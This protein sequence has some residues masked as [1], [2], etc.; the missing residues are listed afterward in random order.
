MIEID[1]AILTKRGN[2]RIGDLNNILPPGIEVNPAL[3]E[4]T[5]LIEMG[6]LDDDAFD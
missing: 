2:V 6:D 1:S 5:V 3:D 4:N